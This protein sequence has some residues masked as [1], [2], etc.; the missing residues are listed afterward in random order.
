MNHLTL[1]NCNARLLEAFPKLQAAFD[2]EREKY[3]EVLH[4][5]LFVH[6]FA[7]T[8]REQM[9]LSLAPDA[10]KNED[11]EMRR[12]KSNALVNFR[13][14]AFDFMEEMANSADMQVVF[15][16]DTGILES[17]LGGKQGDWA[18][19]SPHFRRSTAKIAGKLAQ[20]M[21]IDTTGRVK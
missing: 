17:L 9:E 3:G 12:Q 5:V 15:L 21:R 4:H 1:E 11:W 2:E 19:F 16:L 13:E 18:R 20:R 10:S 7:R 8:L 6:I 14:R